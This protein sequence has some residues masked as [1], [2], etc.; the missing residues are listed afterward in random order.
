MEGDGSP[1]DRLLPA[2]TPP[3]F[4]A[5]IIEEFRELEF[6][7]TNPADYELLRADNQAALDDALPVSQQLTAAVATSMH[8][9]ERR[10][11]AL[12][13]E[14]YVLPN[15]TAEDERERAALARLHAAGHDV[16]RVA[17]GLAASTT[18]GSRPH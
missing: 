11:R 7:G 5:A 18:P 9:E 17:C 8:E 2:L 15:Q 13:Q 10:M 3:E 6:L 4:V 14:G 1:R 16:S 12:R